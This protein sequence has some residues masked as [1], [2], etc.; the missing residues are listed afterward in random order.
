[1]RLLIL[2]FPQRRQIP[3]DIAIK[4]RQLQKKLKKREGNNKEAIADIVSDQKTN[5]ENKARL[6]ALPKAE[7][8]D[9]KINQTPSDVT[10]EQIAERQTGQAWLGSGNDVVRT[11]YRPGY[12]ASGQYNHQTRSCCPV[13]LHAYHVVDRKLPAD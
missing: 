7:I 8:S 1:M 2:L 6:E 9:A 4:S 3:D 5:R 10:P 13:S 12:Y 11:G